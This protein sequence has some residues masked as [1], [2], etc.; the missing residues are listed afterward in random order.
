M[1]LIDGVAFQRD[2]P[3][4][5][6]SAVRS[7]DEKKI[8]FDKKPLLLRYLQANW[9]TGT[10][11]STS[12]SFALSFLLDTEKRQCFKHCRFSNNKYFIIC[13]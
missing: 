8:I 2:R 5:T 7:D 11:S 3:V 6:R 1:L 12:V 9:G 10:N 13:F 4:I